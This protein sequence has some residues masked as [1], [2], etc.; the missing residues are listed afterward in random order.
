MTLF[1]FRK[2]LPKIIIKYGKL[3]D[4]V[5]IFYCRNNPALKDR[6]WNDWIPPSYEEV[7][8]RIKNY[9]QEWEKNE[10]KI[11]DGICD[12]LSLNFIRNKIDVYI[13]SGNP[14]QLSDPLIIK[15]GFKPD[16]FVDTLTHELIHKLFED[17]TPKI[18]PRILEEMFPN[19]T[20]KTRNHVIV[21]AVL[22]HIYLDVLNDKMRLERNIKN[23]KQHDTHDYARAWEIIEKEGYGEL[24][25]E[26]KKK[27]HLNNQ[28]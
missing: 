16:E 19:E 6:G 15:S 25:D 13:V 27:Y 23:S 9:R 24:I 14:R 7:L 18:P 26:F 2:K 11:L 3:L 12:I 4:P 21:Y 5:F 22:K 17:N 8:S 10:K 1:K 28:Y 20:Q